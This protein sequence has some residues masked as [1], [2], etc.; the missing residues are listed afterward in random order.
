MFSSV[1]EP[2]KMVVYG[3]TTETF[4]IP[5]LGPEQ[6]SETFDIFIPIDKNYEKDIEINPDRSI[7]ETNYENNIQYSNSFYER[8]RE[9]KK[10]KDLKNHL[11]GLVKKLTQ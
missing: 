7:I 4:I 8:K 11:Y 2:V 6:E 10:Q 3:D 9:E 5:S 1:S